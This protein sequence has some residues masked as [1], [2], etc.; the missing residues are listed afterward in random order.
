MENSPDLL[1]DMT[2]NEKYFF[3]E[4]DKRIR[5]IK[6]PYNGVDFA[7]KDFGHSL[8]IVL[9]EE[10]IMDRPQSEIDAIIEW[11][12]LMGQLIMSK[13]IQCYIVGRKS[14]GR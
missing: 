14:I 11:A 4:L 8:A 7:V 13:G 1:S 9:K 3:Y 10:Q 2:P 6:C 5:E 12:Q